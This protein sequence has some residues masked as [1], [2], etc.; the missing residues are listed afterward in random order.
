[1]DEFHPVIRRLGE[2]QAK[3]CCMNLYLGEG[4][5]WY[6]YEVQ[7][8]SRECLFPLFVSDCVRSIHEQGMIHQ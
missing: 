3:R 1:M 8:T 7:S 4:Q 6:Q 2:Q 5:P